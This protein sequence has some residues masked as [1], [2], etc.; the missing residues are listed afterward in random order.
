MRLP[1]TATGPVLNQN[2]TGTEVAL[3][4]RQNAWRSGKHVK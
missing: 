1:Y 4:A 2:I 3:N